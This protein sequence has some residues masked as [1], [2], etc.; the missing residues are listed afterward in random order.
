MKQTVIHPESKEQY[1]SLLQFLEKQGYLWNGAGELPTY[2]RSMDFFNNEKD[3]CICLEPD[4][5]ITYSRKSYFHCHDNRY[6][7]ISFNDY[8]DNERPNLNLKLI[9]AVLGFTIHPE[10]G[11]INL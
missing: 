8:M 7:I 11:K 2:S 9:K 3:I 10:H 1:I 4:K 6:N 5:F